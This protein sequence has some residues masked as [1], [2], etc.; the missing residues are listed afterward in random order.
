MNVN[1]QNNKMKFDFELTLPSLLDILLILILAISYY[2]IVYWIMYGNSP[3][4]L[5]QLEDKIY[6][7]EMDIIELHSEKYDND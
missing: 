3:H 5:K 1:L 7:L 6:R 4:R 2:F